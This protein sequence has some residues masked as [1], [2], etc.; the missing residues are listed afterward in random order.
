MLSHTFSLRL[1]FSGGVGVSV[2]KATSA[3]VSGIL[4]C[5]SAAF[6]AYRD[7]YTPAAFVDTVLT[8]E[9]IRRRLEEMTVFVAM[10]KSGTIVD[11]PALIKDGVRNRTNG[12]RVL[13]SISEIGIV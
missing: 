2:R 3:D 11:I 5:L 12:D 10:D 6:E 13:G 8:P 7:S 4:A 9:T 1:A